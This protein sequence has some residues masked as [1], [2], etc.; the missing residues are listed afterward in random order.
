MPETNKN[1]FIDEILKD[2]KA[3]VDAIVEELRKASEPTEPEETPEAPESPEEGETGDDVADHGLTVVEFVEDAVR[4]L[5]SAEQWADEVI[6]TNHI[7]IADRY[8]Q[9]A[10]FTARYG[11]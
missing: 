10:E 4:N 5:R 2:A 3:T 9:L 1:P 7:Q 11:A 8:L 6:V